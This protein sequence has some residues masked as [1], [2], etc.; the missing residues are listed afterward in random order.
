VLG[1]DAPFVHLADL[2][3]PTTS[4]AEELAGE[5]GAERLAVVSVEALGLVVLTQTCDLVRTC[6]DRP[7]VEV[8]PLVEM[9]DHEAN[10]CV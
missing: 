9:P 5:S 10:W 1:S 7:F 3:A 6:T 2:D 4:H 8:C